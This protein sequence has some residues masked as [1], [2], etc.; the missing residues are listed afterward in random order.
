MVECNTDD[1]RVAVSVTVTVSKG[2][3]RHIAVPIL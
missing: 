3:V 2:A 1:I